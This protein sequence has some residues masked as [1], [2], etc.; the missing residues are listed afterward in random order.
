MCEPY[1][2]VIIDYEPDLGKR[3]VWHPTTDVGPFRRLSRGAFSVPIKAVMWAGRF[4]GLDTAWFVQRIECFPLLKTEV[5][6]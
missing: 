3:T 5:E 6:E 2:T 1:Y 4:L